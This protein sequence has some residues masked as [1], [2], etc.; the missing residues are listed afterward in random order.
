MEMQCNIKMGES[1]KKKKKSGRWK[2]MISLDLWPFICSFLLS[3]KLSHG[4]LI[5]LLC[6]DCAGDKVKFNFRCKWGL[7]EK[8]ISPPP[9]HILLSFSQ[10]IKLPSF[11]FSFHF[12]PFPTFLY[13]KFNFM[14][15]LEE[16]CFRWEW[17]KS[18][19]SCRW[20]W[21]QKSS[22]LLFEYNSWIN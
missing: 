20:L 16:Y 10:L 21:W 15:F 13:I 4:H 5:W 9:H 7:Y 19:W 1:D 22:F 11:P 17:E 6:N 14:R 12:F 2:R 18:W 8:S 3:I